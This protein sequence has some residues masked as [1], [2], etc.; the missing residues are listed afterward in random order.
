MVQYTDRLQY[1]DVL[2]CEY[3]SL[4]DCLFETYYPACDYYYPTNDG[5]LLVCTIRSTETECTAV[6]HDD[7]LD[8]HEHIVEAAR[9]DAV[10]VRNPFVTAFCV[11]ESDLP[12]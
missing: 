2:A 4:F 11:D 9:L 8:F 6:Y 1:N 7:D 3:S 12:F 5:D 10:H